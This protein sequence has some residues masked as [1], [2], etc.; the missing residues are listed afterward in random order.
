MAVLTG[1]V[2]T[3][4]AAQPAVAPYQWK[5]V[6]IIAGGYVP[7]IIFSPAQKDL[8][9]CRTDIGGG[10]RWDASAQQWMPLTDFLGPANWNYLGCESIAPD[11]RDPQKLYIAGGMYGSG[12]A[13][14]LRSDDGG[15]TFKIT[16]VPFRMGGNEDGRGIGERLTVDPADTQVLYFGSRHDGLWKSEDAAATWKKVE[17]FPF[18][19]TSGARRG[20]GGLTANISAG[21]AFVIFDP[22]GTPDGHPTKS[23][24]VGVADNSPAHLFHSADAGASWEA[25]ASQPA[26]LLPHHAALDGNGVLYIAYSSVI[27]PNT[28]PGVTITGAVWKLD[29]KNGQW[30]DI[31]P[32]LTG[33]PG[34]F[35]GVSVDRQHPGTLIV[36][37]LDHWNPGDDL[38]RSTD[39]GTT[40]K[41]VRAQA[42]MDP[43]LSPYLHWGRDTVRFGWWISA[44]AVDPF[45]G[46]HVL[47]GTGATIWGTHDIANVLPGQ[48]THWTVAAAGIEETAV[49]DL[50][51]PP[52]GAHLLS[53]VGDIGGFRHDDFA[54]SPATGMSKEP[55]FT[56]T[57]SLDYAEL[58]P[59][60]MVRSG[61]ANNT[62]AFSYSEDGGATWKPL[63]APAA[64]TTTGRRGGGGG[65]QAQGTVIVS[66]DGGTFLCTRGT[67]SFS[68][69]R[70]QTWTPCAG[71]RA[72]LRPV[73]DRANA[74]KFY[75]LDAANGA[76]LTSTDGGA[77]FASTAVAG[78]P[79][80]GGGA[81]G[82]GPR[83]LV[84]P[85]K[86]GDLWAVAGRRLYHSIDGG[87]NFIA[88]ESAAAVYTMGFGKAA[89]GKNYPALYMTGNVGE[90][91]GIFRSDDAGA[92]WV[93]VNDDQHQYGN[94]PTIVTGDPRIYGRVYIGT[95]GRGIFYGEPAAEK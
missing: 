2:A 60:V 75:A 44:L 19:G 49:L 29:T 71:L 59:E 42:Q 62:T 84:V 11:P 9:Y 21:V 32:K 64:T 76:I 17:N 47:F 16:E 52:A 20:G 74:K 95:N 50:I 68:T 43:T 53:A 7:G 56:N 65:G 89:P 58:Q 25:V 66:A 12:Q 55:V 92:T 70:G 81:R 23:L 85:G 26:G 13:A 1:G 41:E 36:S 73:A 88:V 22:Q 15:K 61:T 6:A 10:Y 34:G 94:Y 28:P 31:S 69:D 86:E 80:G 67:P 40:W 39:G 18:A 4:A 63:N 48:P 82:G 35:S 46:D 93:R 90:V 79:A 91:G 33:G 30:T 14:I 27:G 38:Y 3:V 24:Y 78:L 5:N 77:I 8:I 37:T 72:G 45:D 83:L 51:S 57:Y 87:A 54:V